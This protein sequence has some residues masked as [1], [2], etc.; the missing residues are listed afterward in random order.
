MGKTKKVKV[1]KS[2]KKSPNAVSRN[3]GRCACNLRKRTAAAIASDAQQSEG[4]SDEPEESVPDTPALKVPAR[5]VWDKYPEHMERLLDYLDAHPDVAI[6]L[7]GDS[8]QATK[9]EG[10]SKLTAKSNKST[11][12]LQVA[13]GVFS[14]DNDVAVRVTVHR[15]RGSK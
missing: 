7:F 14:I 12:Y 11:G 2:P 5:V 13:D 8:T 4:S 6:K 1:L 15:D 9:L 3:K 10:R